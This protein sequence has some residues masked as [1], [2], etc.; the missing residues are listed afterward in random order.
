MSI[1]L[2]TSA[3]A[4]M[5]LALAAATLP[6]TPVLPSVWAQ[7]NIYL[8][9]GPNKGEK[10]DLN[11]T[12]YLREIL[13][14]FADACPDNKA[15]VRKSKQTGFSTAA[16][17][18]AGYTAVAEPCDL[19]LIEPTDSNLRD[20]IDDKLQLTI[21]ASPVFANALK[22]QVS[23]SGKGS[24][25]YTKRFAG[26][27]LLM[28]TASSTSELRGKT[29][30]KVIRDEASEYK[31]DLDGQGSPHDMIS[32]AYESFLKAGDWKDLEISTP[33]VKGECHIDAA[34][35]AG[36]QRYWHHVCPGC[37]AKFYFKFD[38]KQFIF[39]ETYPL[40]A[41]YVPE[42]CGVPIEEYQ[43]AELM[44]TAERNGG[45]W[46]ATAA[47]PGKYR[48]YHF[49]ALSSPFVPWDEIARRCLESKGHPAKQKTF[50]NLT[51]GLAYEIIGNAP[52]HE[53]LMTLR[54]ADLKRR[55][56]PP[57]G[58]MMV[59]SADVQGNGIYYEILALAPDRQ[60]W[61]VDAEF[62]P[63]DTTD[64]EGGAFALLSEVYDRE[65]PDAFGGKRRVD[66]FG[67]DSGYRANVVYAWTSKRMN[68]MALKGMDGWSRPAISTA[69]PVDVDMGG[70]RIKAGAA[71]WLVGTYSLKAVFYDDLKKKRVLEGAD[72]EPAGACHYGTWADEIIFKQQTAEY[73]ATE[74]IRGRNR[75]VWKESGPNH[76]LDCRVQNMALAD[77]LGLSRMSVD[78]WRMLARERAKPLIDDDGLFAPRPIAIQTAGDIAA[79]AD[80][81]PAAAAPQALAA[82]IEAGPAAAAPWIAPRFDWMRRS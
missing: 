69:A 10:F 60:S 2:K 26:G 47:A 62:L 33:V 17:I 1:K 18:L 58:L 50:Y 23:R 29:R 22:P 81:P 66:K 25:T 64:A 38:L 71:L 13:D 74:T 36:D 16:I 77:W 15:S 55:H 51:L 31:A 72:C 57:Y 28:A 8:A 67:V 59:G 32:G 27:S 34:F 68:A 41:H 40:N 80:L 76:F 49:D 63:G 21:E 35:E 56:I 61:Q 46:I 70:R 42:C 54:E 65:Y 5:A 6:P 20:F 9:D 43:R 3:L 44:Q 37:Q 4:V 39:N 75:R 30:R 14:F 53:R 48:S 19:F 45:G 12:P 73:V 11:R 7:E 82:E 78:E 52:S 24:T 79:P